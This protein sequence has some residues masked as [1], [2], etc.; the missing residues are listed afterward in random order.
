[1]QKIIGKYI[2]NDIWLSRQTIKGILTSDLASQL[3]DKNSGL[4]LLTLPEYIKDFI[5]RL[6]NMEKNMEKQKSWW[7]R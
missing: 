4:Q 1:M 7:Q 3:E 5:E 2:E 6:D